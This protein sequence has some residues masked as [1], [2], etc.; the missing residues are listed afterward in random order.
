ML[1]T[2]VS[3][4]LFLEKGK[5]SDNETYIPR[6][7]VVHTPSL[8]I[9][10]KQ[11]QEQADLCEFEANLIYR[12]CQNTRVPGLQRNPILK[13]NKIKQFSPTKCVGG[14]DSWEFS[15]TPNKDFNS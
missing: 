7:A 13:N 8:T 10:R 6:Q 14:I 15:H 4:Y 12:K 2:I 9:F 1:G 3:L 5:K 11:E